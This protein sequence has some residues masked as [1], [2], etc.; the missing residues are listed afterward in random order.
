MRDF[1]ILFIRVPAT[2]AKLARPGGARV[3]LAESL[4]VKHQLGALSRG[5]ERAPNPRPMDRVIAGLRVF[6]VRRGRMVRSANVFRPTILLS[7][8]RTLVKRKCRL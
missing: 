6:F 8:H 4:L 5:R 7:F 2:I 1:A 3:V